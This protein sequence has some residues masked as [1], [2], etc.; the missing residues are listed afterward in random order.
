MISAHRIT[1]SESGGLIRAV[2]TRGKF[3]LALI[4]EP[5]GE[6]ETWLSYSYFRL[7]RDHAS[8]TSVNDGEPGLVR[9]RCPRGAK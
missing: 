1:F 9:Y 2:V 4:A 3:E 6:G 8:I 7:A 5:S